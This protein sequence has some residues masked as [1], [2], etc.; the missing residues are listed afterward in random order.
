MTGDEA[1]PPPV[2]IL[3]MTATGESDDGVIS[4][5]VRLRNAPDARGRDR[6]LQRL[7][8]ELTSLIVKAVGAHSIGSSEDAVHV[9]VPRDQLEEA[10]R[11]IR[12]AVGEFN[13]AYPSLLVEHRREVERIE[14]EKAAKH[15]RLQAD[16]QVIDRVMNE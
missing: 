16:Q 11:A 3:S 9:Q 1:T 4:I 2:E 14:A 15:E 12:W 8:H 6:R 5:N 10:V 13:E 7:H